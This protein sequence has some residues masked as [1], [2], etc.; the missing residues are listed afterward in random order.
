MKL[1]DYVKILL[2]NLIFSSN[3]A[4]KTLSVLLLESQKCCVTSCMISAISAQN[5]RGR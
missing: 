4:E 5:Y 2:Q 1:K 3:K